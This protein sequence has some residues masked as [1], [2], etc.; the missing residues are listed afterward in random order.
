MGRQR[1]QTR[2]ETLMAVKRIRNA[3]YVVAD[4]ERMLAFYRDVLGLTL[5]FRDGDRWAQFDVAGAS[6]ALSSREE[7]ASAPGAGAVV[8]LEVDDLDATALALGRAGVEIVQPLR[9]MGAH[10]R[11][12][13]IRDTGGNI[14]QLYQRAGA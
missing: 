10:G 2:E 12:M 6:L 3:Y 4:M 7:G 5:K 9:D 13:A 1:T 8:T 11:T 14:V